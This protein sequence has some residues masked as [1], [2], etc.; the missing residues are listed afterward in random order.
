MRWDKNNI[1][2]KYKKCRIRSGT[3]TSAAVNFRSLPFGRNSSTN[4]RN[5][6]LSAATIDHDKSQKSG[7][8]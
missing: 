3:G 1:H 8:F 6:F 5:T 4:Q 2:N 7:N